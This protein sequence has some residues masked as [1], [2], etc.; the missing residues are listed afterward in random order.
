MGENKAGVAYR[1][2]FCIVCWDAGVGESHLFALHLLEVSEHI[3]VCLIA[4]EV[5][6]L[7]RVEYSAVVWD[8]KSV[9]IRRATEWNA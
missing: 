1:V 9:K 2:E 6:V 8:V 7:H 4:C 3:R 5:G